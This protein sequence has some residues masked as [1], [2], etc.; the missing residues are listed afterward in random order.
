MTR[1]IEEVAITQLNALKA[2][3]EAGKLP[4]VYESFYMY[5]FDYYADFSWDA[6]IRK[7]VEHMKTL[8]E[9]D[10]VMDGIK[11]VFDFDMRGDVEQAIAIHPD[12]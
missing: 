12:E 6:R 4:D 5:T 9:F 3:V 8:P 2:L 1:T 10:E 7:E 11:R